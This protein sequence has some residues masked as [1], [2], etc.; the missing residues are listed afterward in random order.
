M[1]KAMIPDDYKNLL[2]YISPA[3]FQVI[4]W[5]RAVVAL[6]KMSKSSFSAGEK[7]DIDADAVSLYSNQLRWS[8]KN[9]V[10]LEPGKVDE[11]FY[12]SQVLDLYFSQFFSERSSFLDLRAKNFAC[13]NRSLWFLSTAMRHQF[14]RKFRLAMLDVYAG[15]YMDDERILKK[16]LSGVGLIK[17]DA[18]EA[19]VT[20]VSEL[21]FAHFGDG[22]SQ[23][24]LFKLD[25]FQKSF[26]SLF[27][28]LKK[29]GVRLESDFLFLGIYLV[30]MYMNLSRLETPLEVSSVFRDVWQRNRE[31]LG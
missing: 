2:E 23:K 16:G 9:A 18:T 8:A 14:S 19:E 25:E 1:I 3:A 27:L 28:W 12:G 20:E 30:T 5:K 24:I 31:V 7:P 26:H 29:R 6:A 13:D 21:L 22:R 15:Y 17:K 10:D 11:M 4:D